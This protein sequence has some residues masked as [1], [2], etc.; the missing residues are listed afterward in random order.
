MQ[1]RVS[2]NDSITI[3]VPIE[4][5]M[6]RGVESLSHSGRPIA[7]RM[8]ERDLDILHEEARALGVNRGA[9]IRWVA[10]YAAAALRLQRTG[11]TI[12]VVP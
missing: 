3:P 5:P 4:L 11:E 7:V 6:R 1:H 9:F 12:E 2:S 8:N 10:V